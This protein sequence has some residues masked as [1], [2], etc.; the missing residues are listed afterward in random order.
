MSPFPLTVTDAAEQLRAG[1]ITSVELTTV[2]LER[3]D[4]LDGQLGAYVTRLDEQA[5]DAAGQADK[6]FAAGIDKSPYQGIPIGIKDILATIDGPTTA[7]SL[8][9]DPAWGAGK[10]GPVVARLRNAGGVITGKLTTME[11][12]CGVADASKPFA[13]PRNPW[14]LETWPGGSSSGTGNGIA[15]GL[16]FAGIGTDTGGSI[17]I[18]AAFCG[19]SGL[20]PT[21]GRVPKSG[22]VPLGY[23]LDHIGPMARSARDCAAMLGVIAGYDPSD[24]SC[25]DRPVDDYLGALTGDL[26]GM[27]I[28]VERAHHFPAGADPA[29]EHCFAAAVAALRELGAEVVEV[30]LPY[31]DETNASMMATGMSEALAY[32]RNDAQARWGDYYDS[33][34][35]MLAYGALVSAADFVQAQRVRRFVQQQLAAVFADVDVIVAP[36]AAIGAPSLASVMSPG[37]FFDFMGL[38]FTSYWDAVGNPALVVPMGFTAAGLPLS[39]QIAGRPFEEA[40]LLKVGD[41]YQSTTGWHL[42]LPPLVADPVAA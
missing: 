42:A 2:M 3:A 16:Y 25:V 19:I 33:T 18:P 12:A 17:R 37:G 10:D 9:L 20:M 32:H 13:V 30:V 26:H 38:L 1:T 6:D 4:L 14:D 11:F 22:C 28:G 5:M 31:Y 23:S 27:R 35:L 7:N 15:A 21:F 36:T 40:S 8:I 34:R 24:E 41:A 39:L 29:L